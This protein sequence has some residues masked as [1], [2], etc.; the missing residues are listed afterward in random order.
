MLIFFFI[1]I[2]HTYLYVIFPLWPHDA[3]IQLQ[4]IVVLVWFTIFLLIIQTVK[5]VSSAASTHC[6]EGFKLLCT[7]SSPF[8]P[9]SLSIPKS[10]HKGRHKE[11]ARDLMTTLYY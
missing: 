8:L 6:L 1:S 11:R 4:Y 2:L 10:T 7:H 9:Q 3:S 5:S